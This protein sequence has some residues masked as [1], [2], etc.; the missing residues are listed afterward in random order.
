MLI[1]QKRTASADGPEDGSEEVTLE[2]DRIEMALAFML[3]RGKTA[4]DAVAMTNE[5]LEASKDLK[6]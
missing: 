3:F 4:K 5:L 1:K 2:L 6:P